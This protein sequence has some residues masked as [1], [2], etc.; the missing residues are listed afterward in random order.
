MSIEK[1]F[2][3]QDAEIHGCDSSEVLG[4]STEEMA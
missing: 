2:G 1:V 3:P 4:G